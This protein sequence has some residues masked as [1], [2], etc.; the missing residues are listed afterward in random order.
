MSAKV[1]STELLQVDAGVM[2]PE[3]ASLVSEDFIK[4][5]NNGAMN[6][7]LLEEEDEEDNRQLCNLILVHPLKGGATDLKKI[8][9]VF[10]IKKGLFD[11]LKGSKELPFVLMKDIPIDEA[12]KNI[13]AL[14]ELGELLKLSNVD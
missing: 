3:F 4:W 9:E 10:N 2:N 11:L 8:Q 6:I 5:I 7:D 12:K 1:N 14:G 13:K